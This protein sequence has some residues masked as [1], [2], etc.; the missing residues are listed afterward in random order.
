M[1]P[2]KV[3]NTIIANSHGSFLWH[4]NILRKLNTLEYCR[5][6][7]YPIDYNFAENNA[8]YLIGMSV[9]PVMI[10]QIANQVYKQWLNKL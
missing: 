1:S 5:I 7:S 6:G 8:K 3:P 10:A 4:H 2:T 9:P